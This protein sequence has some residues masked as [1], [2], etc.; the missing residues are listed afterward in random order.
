[1]LPEPLKPEFLQSIVDRNCTVDF[2]PHDLS[3]DEVAQ[4]LQ[5]LADAGSIGDGRAMWFDLAASRL[6]AL[7]PN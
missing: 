7:L 4:V 1:M 5:A 6:R 3:N 2:N